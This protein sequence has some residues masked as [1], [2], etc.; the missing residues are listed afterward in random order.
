MLAVLASN[1]QARQRH[2]GHLSSLSADLRH[3]AHKPQQRAL[4]RGTPKDVHPSTIVTVHSAE[5]PGVDPSRRAPERTV[6]RPGYGS[7][8][9]G[10]MRLRWE[11]AVRSVQVADREIRARCT[12]VDCLARLCCG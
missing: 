11:R 12:A 9:C 8:T 7:G 6:A 5:P 10:W 1:P 4:F 2:N 3:A